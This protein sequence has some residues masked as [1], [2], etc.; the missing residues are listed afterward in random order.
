MT[1]SPA[2]DQEFDF[3]VVGSGFGGSVSALRLSEK[4]YRVAV[5]E[6]GR[7][8]NPDNLP[9]KSWHLSRWLWKPAIG[10]RGFFSMKIF[11]HA[12][13]VHGCGVGG[14]SIGYANT[15]LKP[16][17]KAF[18]SGTW[19]K[20]AD[21]S[22][23]LAPHFE[24]ASK[25]LGIIENR[26]LGPSDHILQKTAEAMGVGATFYRTQ[27][28]VFQEAEGKP[29]GK[30]Y[31]DP[32]FGGAGPERNTCIACGGCM[33][34][35]QHNAKNSLDKNYLYFAE[36]NGVQIF[37][38]TKVTDVLPINSGSDGYVVIT[39]R[40]RLNTK[41]VVLAASSLGTL[42]L[43]F[44]LKEKGSLPKISKALGTRVLTNSESLVGIRI[45]DSKMDLSSGIAIGSG[46][47][48]DEHTHIEATR[49]SHQGNLLALTTTLMT[50]G[51]LGKGRV[52]LWLR[53]L[54]NFLIRHPINFFKLHMPYR[55]AKEVVIFLCMQTL[56][57]HIKMSWQRKWY[58]PFSKS[59]VTE[60]QQIPTFIPKAN[61]FAVQAAKLFGGTALSMSS[62]ILFDIPS[63]AHILGGCPMSD[64]EQLGVIN[65]RHEVFGY[66]N[67][68]I[69]DGSAVSANLG[70]NPSLTICALS[71]RAMSFI[72]SKKTKH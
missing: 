44:S 36:K 72:P 26:I 37:S 47:Y 35:C 55:W 52:W 18:Q 20:L 11:R 49:Y 7:R 34:G 42:E 16:P 60:G 22:N 2:F 5:V 8:F 71:E 57:G 69:C 40:G 53:S 58:W 68:F 31:P 27:V 65:H 63:T 43:L 39:S 1:H 70:V 30:L 13:V 51:A 9:K 12:L 46:V 3:V 61:E 41:S 4:G 48:I 19:A 54:L 6:Q 32:Y 67:L 24:R 45:P 38:E 14:G 62:E 17:A 10:L 33:M 66:E 56:D 25:M 15:L 64:T 28:G 29:G 23:E 59:L 21:W 50:R